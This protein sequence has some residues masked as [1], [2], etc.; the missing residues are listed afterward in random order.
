MCPMSETRHLRAVLECPTAPLHESEVMAFISTFGSLRGL[1]ETR[2]AYGNLVLTH[3]GHVGLP[4]EGH[5]GQPHEG[6]VGQPHEG[7]APL[8]F[9]AATDHP[10]C[11]IVAVAGNIA[12]AIWHG[13]L[14]AA[15][16][17]DARLRFFG[18][19]VPRAAR[20]TSL[21][22]RTTPG[23]E[24]VVDRLLLSPEGRVHVG[25]FGVLDFPGVSTEGEWLRARGASQLVGTG[26]LLELLDRLVLG[27]LVLGRSTAR[28]QAVF[29]RASVLM[30][31]GALAALKS[32]IFL[33]G[34]SVI[35]VHG[36]PEQPGASCGGGPVLRLGDALGLYDPGLCRALA[37]MASRHHLSDGHPFQVAHLP[38][39]H[40]DAGVLGLHGLSTAAIT[41][42]IRGDG[43]LGQ[44]R[45]PE[46]F[47]TSD[48]LACVDLM[49]TII[50]NWQGP[51]TAIRVAAE[52]RAL[53]A[54]AFA[55]SL[56]RLRGAS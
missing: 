49:A 35:S 7:H 45:Q 53:I 43:E 5:V 56:P 19:N 52:R 9:L 41:V 38:V 21:S 44:G 8:T 4:H 2:D 51:E 33:A 55:G 10:G 42:P 30:H 39:G 25:D 23:G 40:S 47:C 18:S 24:V 34:Q 50:S 12:E 22:T 36:C 37:Q 1:S 27:R 26:L 29:V 20:I 3:E 31:A 48:A 46:W 15:S 14:P 13:E 32:G 11:E 28:V 54:E 17:G 6:H 16:I